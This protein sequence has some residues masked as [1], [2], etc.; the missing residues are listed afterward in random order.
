[1]KIHLFHV[2]RSLLNF[3]LN[4]KTRGKIDS[5]FS[6]KSNVQYIPRGNFNK[7]FYDMLMYSNK[8]SVYWWRKNVFK[9]VGKKWTLWRRENPQHCLFDANYIHLKYLLLQILISWLFFG[10]V[11]LGVWQNSQK[12]SPNVEEKV[13]GLLNNQARVDHPTHASLSTSRKRVVELLNWMVHV[14]SL[15]SFMPTNLTN[16]PG[17]RKSFFDFV[18]FI[19]FWSNRFIWFLWI[20]SFFLVVDELP[21][22]F[23]LI[24]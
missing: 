7:F 11:L 2:E 17:A 20:H 6:N 8:F 18:T 10:Q 12:S 14:K 21:I 19:R 9:S 16:N 4:E 24:F 5:N 3:D 13:R 1:M 22:F 23:F 15:V